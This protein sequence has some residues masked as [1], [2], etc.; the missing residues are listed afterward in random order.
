VSGAADG[1]FAEGVRIAAEAPRFLEAVRAAVDYRGDV[2]VRR[3]DGSTLEGYLFDAV[4]EGDAPCLRVLPS[5]GERVRVPLA[6]VA[7]IAFTGK[8]TA[9]GKTWENWVRR[10]VE[11]RLAGESADLPSEPLGD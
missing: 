2:T 4:A 10:Y 11:K 3:R 5:Q 8:D 6:E 1:A 7:E 9:S